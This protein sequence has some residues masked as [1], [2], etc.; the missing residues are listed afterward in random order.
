MLRLLRYILLELL[1]SR[2]TLFYTLLL[3]LSTIGLY[4]IDGDPAK[5]MLSLLNIL[6]I[7]VP[8]VSLVF[9]TIHFH[10][11][12]EFIEL[13]LSQPVPRYRVF[14]AEYLATALS[15]G[16][17]FV[18][19]I[20]FPMLLF[21]AG[22]S[23][24]VLLGAGFLLTIVFVGLAFLASVLTRD[25]ARAIGI[26]LLFWFYFSLIYDAFLLWILYSFS[27][28][29]MD[30]PTLALVSL[31]PIDLARILM[32]LQ[33]DVSA[34][35]GYTGAFFRNFFGSNAGMFFSLAG[36]LVWAV[37]PIALANRIFKR[38]DL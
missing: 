4:Q 11:S 26:A 21:G 13:M 19:G 27:D 28:Y 22:S 15:L 17:A 32:L 2:F 8:L 34:L 5:V 25:K 30:M 36:L 10:N 16:L 35:M 37:W 3:S 6:L 20:G 18:F 7:V 12:Y 1:R 24:F 31:N 14:L 29:P 33:L 38:K 9:S 23:S